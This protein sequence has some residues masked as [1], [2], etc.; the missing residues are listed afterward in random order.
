MTNRVARLYAA[1]G[2]LAALFLAWAGVAARPSVEPPHDPR[3]AALAQREERLQRDAALV[4]QV[5]DRRWA[6]YRATLASPQATAAPAPSVRVV[7]L[8]PVAQ[9][10]SS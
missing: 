2:A 8:P 1:A 3:L 9:T 10:R 4:Q 6:A 7:T 5:V